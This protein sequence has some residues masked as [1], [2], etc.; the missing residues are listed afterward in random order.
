MP[1]LGL[2]QGDEFHFSSVFEMCSKILL[3]LYVKIRFNSI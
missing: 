1:R 2:T 3:K